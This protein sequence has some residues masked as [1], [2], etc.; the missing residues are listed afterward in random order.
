[1]LWGYS[2]GMG[3]RWLTV[4][5]PGYEEGW[6][7]VE[8]GVHG[9]LEVRS[10]R[11]LRDVFLGRQRRGILPC[12]ASRDWGSG[13]VKQIASSINIRSSASQPASHPSLCTNLSFRTN[14]KE[15]ALM[16]YFHH[17]H[18][19]Y[20]TPLRPL[21]SATA[22]LRCGV[23]AN[24]AMIKSTNSSVSNSSPSPASVHRYLISTKEL[25]RM[26]AKYRNLSQ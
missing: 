12:L 20:L 2:S 9:A 3:W 17:R 11:V 19:P 10:R 6:E 5:F 13:S 18:P 26:L 16:P 1:M 23:S 8:G 7:G 15:L 21:I 25:S 14:P 24:K 22:L 4:G